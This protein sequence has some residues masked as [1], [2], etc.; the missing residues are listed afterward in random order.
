MGGKGRTTIN[1]PPPI[2][3]GVAMGEYL[4]GQGFTNYS[5]VTDPR[6]QERLLAAEAQYRP[7][8]T[9]L[10]LADQEAALFG[11]Q[12]REAGEGY[13]AQK[14]KVASLQAQLSKLD[15]E[16]TE[17][18]RSFRG[19]KGKTTTKDNPQY[20]EL[21]RQLDV[22]QGKL[23]ELAPIAAQEGLLGMQSRAAEI[24][25][26]EDT[27]Q[28]QREMAQLEQF[29][30]RFT[31]AVRAADPESFEAAQATRDLADTFAEDRAGVMGAVGDIEDFTARAETAFDEDVAGF[32]QDREEFKSLQKDFQA[33]A[34]KLGAN[35][36]N[37][38]PRVDMLSQLSADEAQRLAS[39]ASVDD[40]R[41]TKLQALQQKQAETLYSE[42]EGK[43]SAE[44]AREADQAARMAGA[45]RGRVGDAST[46]AQ[47]L[48][49]RESTRSALRSEARTA[50]GLAADQQGMIANQRSQRA[51]DAMAAGQLGFGMQQGAE[52]MRQGRRGQAMQMA[53]LGLQAGQQGMQAGSQAMQGTQ[54]GLSAGMQG[55][56]MGLSARRLGSQLGQ[57]QQGALGQAFNQFRATAGDPTA[58]LFGR[59][60]L[61]G[62]L[63]TQ[64]YGQAF[65]L[66]GQQQGPQLF[67]PNT[68]INM[69]LQQRSQDTSLLGA[70]AQADAT[71]R[72][73]SLGM[74]G[75]ALGGYLGGL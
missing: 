29:G 71:R 30:G 50:G 3:P 20:L 73:G 9:G 51:R 33:E 25:G 13:Q 24:A 57:A 47:E 52:A 48:L 43:L 70:Q 68:G 56:Q 49:G 7:L 37:L 28:K 59:P 34:D 35:V 63:G 65:N 10:E 74:F 69:A 17:T 39:E 26:Q 2:D 58:F 61:S 67:D 11:V 53:G 64:A 46:L 21:K 23:K 1:Q 14:D 5:G 4:F 15:P 12:G 62:S 22:E 36:E 19:I 6:L 55:R 27:K 16:I 66:A 72:A 41:L 44:R 60:S 40:P 42:S 31:D 54:A 75:S 32:R 8:Y 45:A 38:D 18:T